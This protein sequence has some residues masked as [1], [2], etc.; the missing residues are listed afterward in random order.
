MTNR[1]LQR[2]IKHTI[3]EMHRR[4]QSTNFQSVVGVCSFIIAYFKCGHKRSYLLSTF[5]DRYAKV[6]NLDRNRINQCSYFEF[7]VG[8]PNVSCRDEWFPKN[9]NFSKNAS[10][11]DIKRCAHLW[12]GVR[13]KFMK[14]WL[15]DLKKEEIPFRYEVKAIINK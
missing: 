1:E 4:Q 8:N 7:G 14:D 6:Y 12:Y 13:I 11:H 3:K 5:V 10:K 15:E 9:Y 2:F